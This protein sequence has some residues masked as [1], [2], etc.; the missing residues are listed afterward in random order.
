MSDF[1]QELE[2]QALKSLLDLP[3][4]FH[5]MRAK[6]HPIELTEYYTKEFFQ[7]PPEDID[8]VDSNFNV[9]MIVSGLEET[10]ALAHI[11]PPC[12][13]KDWPLMQHTG[14][15][16][17]WHAEQWGLVNLI[18]WERIFDI[19]FRTAIDGREVM[20]S[21]INMNRTLTENEFYFSFFKA[22]DG[23]VVYDPKGKL[24]KKA[25]YSKANDFKDVWQQVKLLLQ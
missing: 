17:H 25:D 1:I 19:P 6:F 14:L 24:E 22:T 12:D 10:Q 16:Q 18:R 15:I 21:G 13:K 23:V 9:F 5:N 3:S 11:M 8:I 7:N 20:K 2:Q 4:K